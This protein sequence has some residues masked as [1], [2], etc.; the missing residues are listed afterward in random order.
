MQLLMIVIPQAR[1]SECVG[2]HRELILRLVLPIGWTRVVCRD[3][4]KILSHYVDVSTV[5]RDTSKAISVAV[6]GTGAQFLEVIH[7]LL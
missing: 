7:S 6:K 5:D 2:V 1:C 4:G 3:R